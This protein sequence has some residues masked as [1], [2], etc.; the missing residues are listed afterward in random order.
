MNFA[1]RNLAEA[2]KIGILGNLYVDFACYV[3]LPASIRTGKA[4]KNQEIAYFIRLFLGVELQIPR[5]KQINFGF[6]PILYASFLRKPKLCQ[7]NV[8]D[9]SKK[10]I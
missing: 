1:S 10:S 4:Y 2:D 9:R 7:P 8:L 6:S 5:K 3:N